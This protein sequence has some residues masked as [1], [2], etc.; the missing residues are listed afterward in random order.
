MKIILSTLF[1]LNFLFGFADEKPVKFALHLIA[2]APSS[3]SKHN[4]SNN[5]HQ[6]EKK[7]PTHKQGGAS[8]S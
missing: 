5:D 1:F 6:Q 3:L 4:G 8:L 7:Q 2:F